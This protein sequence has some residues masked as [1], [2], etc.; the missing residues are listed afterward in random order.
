VEA[1]W[2]CFPTVKNKII[3]FLGLLLALSGGIMAY[4]DKLDQLQLISPKVAQW[5]PVV[6]AAATFLDRLVRVVGD[7]LDDGQMNQSFGKVLV[8]L[9]AVAAL[10]F[11]GCSSLQGFQQTQSRSYGLNY[12][13][14]TNSMLFT[15]SFSPSGQPRSGRGGKQIVQPQNER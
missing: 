10:M 13:P 14:E 4:A 15:V 11:S 8:T 6:L 2:I 1:V 12:A 5:W 7:Y 9:S 3:N